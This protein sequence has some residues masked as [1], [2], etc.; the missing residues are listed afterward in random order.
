[1]GRGGETQT[2]TATAS[3][4]HISGWCMHL[5]TRRVRVRL[6]WP[7]GWLVTPLGEGEGMEWARIRRQ[8]RLKCDTTQD[9]ANGCAQN[10]RPTRQWTV[11]SVLCKPLCSGLSGI[12]A[13][14]YAWPVTRPAFQGWCTLVAHWCIPR[15]KSGLGRVMN[16]PKGQ[17]VHAGW[18]MCMHTAP[19]GFCPCPS[20]FQPST[21]IIIIISY[22]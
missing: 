19:G 14:G 21:I 4:M 8:A 16:G 2:A 12:L 5:H 1:M 9:L 7:I 6:W 22:H 3:P 13:R 17:P 15:H 11:G 18:H 20:A 10:A